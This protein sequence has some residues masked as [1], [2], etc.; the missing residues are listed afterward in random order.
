MKYVLLTDNNI[1]AEVIPDYNPLFPDKSLQERYP[2]NFILTLLPVD[3]NVE[4]DTGYQYIKETNEF[5]QKVVLPP[6]VDERISQLQSQLEST[7]A[8]LDSVLMGNITL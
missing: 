1:V 5:V 4:V 7:Q 6:T 2:E 8:M 3:D